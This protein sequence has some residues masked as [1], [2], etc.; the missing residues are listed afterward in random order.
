M[1]RVF[2]VLS[3]ASLLMPQPHS[4]LLLVAE[5]GMETR[6]DVLGTPFNLSLAVLVGL[7]G[8][9]APIG[10]SLALLPTAFGYELL[11]SFAL[12]AALASTSLGTIFAV[13]SAVAPEKVAEEKPAVNAATGDAAQGA[14]EQTLHGMGSTLVGT[15][16]VGAALLDDI[17][18]LVLSGVVKQL[19]TLSEGASPSPWSIAK[20][21]VSSVLLILVSALL[22]RFVL[23]PIARLT[24]R[25]IARAAVSSKTQGTVEKYGKGSAA[26]A[27]VAVLC[28]FVTISHEIGSTML[29]GAFCAGA[30]M[31]FGE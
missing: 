29:L 16:L 1:S 11:E 23:G 2:A 17:I 6:L 3:L 25:R 4:L 26:F 10:L 7:T 15:V 9:A 18:G 21:V 20:P 8:I 13:M 30:V 19:G 14:E 24:A 31:T 28:A 5:G 22:S 27:F 12:G